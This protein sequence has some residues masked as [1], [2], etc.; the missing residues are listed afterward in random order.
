MNWDVIWVPAAEQELADAWLN[1]PDRDAVTRA[2][3]L[4]DVQLETGPNN[5]G[6]A[7]TNGRRTLLVQ[8]LG[9]IYRILQDVR[10]VEVL[11]VWRLP[12]G[13]G[14]VP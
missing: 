3:H 5:A 1:A 7:S 11:H 14:Q 6:Q 8:P 13:N 12:P 4:I 9:V 2:A 10:R